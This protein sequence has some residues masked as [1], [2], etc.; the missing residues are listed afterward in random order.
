M[1]TMRPKRSILPLLSLLPLLPLLRLMPLLLSTVLAGASCWPAQAAAQTVARAPAPP[2]GRLFSTPDERAMLDSLRASGG[3][4]ADPAATAPAMPEAGP[5]PGSAPP[6][7]P[8]PLTLNGVVRRSDGRSTVWVNQVA[9]EQ[10]GRSRSKAGGSAAAMP[11]Q[12]SSG[13]TVLLKPGQRYDMDDGSVK[14]L[15]EH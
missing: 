3:L 12:S 7:P 4:T 2:L 13:R 6:P 5:G 15:D 11:L 9:Q 8:P 1:M 14:E 10:Q